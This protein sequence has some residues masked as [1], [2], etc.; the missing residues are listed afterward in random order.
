[1]LV[2]D[3]NIISEFLRPIMAASVDRWLKTV[4]YSE[5]FLTATTVAEVLYG[6][7]RMPEGR[8]K[9]EAT[10]AIHGILAALAERLVPFDA[11]SA[12]HYADI[13]SKR[14][15]M[16]RRVSVSD[17][18]ITAICRQHGATLATRNV[19]DFLHTGVELVNP[20]EVDVVS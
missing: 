18:Q 7:A 20:W 14:E 12:V 15:S 4:D 16:G 19:K 13:V 5:I 3:T 1:M 6:I 11:E 17:G 8:R 2:L 9:R 10:D